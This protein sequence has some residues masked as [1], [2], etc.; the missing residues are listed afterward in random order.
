MQNFLGSLRS[1]ALFNIIIN[2]ALLKNLE[3]N[4]CSYIFSSFYMAATVA[5]VEG[6]FDMKCKIF[7]S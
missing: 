6:N 7:G 2:I 3:N 5:A 4:T 1:P